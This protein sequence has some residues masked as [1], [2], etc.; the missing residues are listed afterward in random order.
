[1]TETLRCGTSGPA[2]DQLLI[3]L[4]RPQDLLPDRNA[5]VDQAHLAQEHERIPRRLHRRAADCRRLG[6]RGRCQK[7][8]T[9]KGKRRT[10]PAI[11]QWLGRLTMPNGEQAIPTVTKVGCESR[12]VGVA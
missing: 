3:A 7:L 12:V 2:D 5:G 8:N 11:L 1:M 9:D 4:D 6:M 10:L